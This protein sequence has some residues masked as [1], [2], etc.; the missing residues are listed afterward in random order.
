MT[1]LQG[2]LMGEMTRLI[3]LGTTVGVLLI[4][5]Q[6]NFNGSPALIGSQRHLLA[7]AA[8]MRCP[9]WLVELDPPSGMAN[10]AVPANTVAGRAMK[11]LVSLRS[12]V[13]DDTPV[14]RKSQFNAFVGTNLVADLAGRG[15]NSHLV[16]LG[17]EGSCCV[18]QTAVGGPPK[19]NAVPL[20][21]ATGHGFTVLST[22]S[23]VSGSTN[24]WSGNVNVGFYSQL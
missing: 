18:K 23:I 3:G 17:H 5:E 11:T 2:S 15:V 19:P 1:L 10:V 21:G 24:S 7:F 12:L 22:A 14:L 16:V 4:D 9:V 13:P 6:G 8:S 20:V